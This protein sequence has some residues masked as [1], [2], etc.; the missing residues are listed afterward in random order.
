MTDFHLTY[1]VKPY[2]TEIYDER[3][4]FMVGWDGH[5]LLSLLFRNRLFKAHLS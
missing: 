1:M 4:F 5:S 2:Q 3:L